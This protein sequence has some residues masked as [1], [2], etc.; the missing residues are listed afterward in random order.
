MAEQLTP[1]TIPI[2]P[3]NPI[4]AK[5]LRAITERTNDLQKQL[6]RKYNVAILVQT[7]VTIFNPKEITKN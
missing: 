6:S 4:H 7:S 3:N 5:I 1:A 2:Q